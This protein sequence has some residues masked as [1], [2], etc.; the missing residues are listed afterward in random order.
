LATGHE[1]K[2]FAGL[3]HLRGVVGKEPPWERTG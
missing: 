2:K 3:A 1:A